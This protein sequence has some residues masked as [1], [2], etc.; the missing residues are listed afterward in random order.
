MTW[1]SVLLAY[2]AAAALVAALSQKLPAQVQRLR[3][4]L[5]GVAIAAVI[6]AVA[7]WPAHDGAALAG[8]SIALCV[9]AM[10][11]VIVPLAPIAPRVIWG[12][13][14][15]APFVAAVLSLCSGAAG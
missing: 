15:I 5:V 8:V 10:A 13:A 9:S 3:W 7:V 11:T 1:V 12:A 2:T 6:G 14:L 4:G